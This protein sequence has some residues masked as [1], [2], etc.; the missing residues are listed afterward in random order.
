MRAG[1]PT[2]LLLDQRTGWRSDA[3]STVSDGSVLELRTRPDG[4]LGLPSPDGSLG[5][6]TLPQGMAFDRSQT[7][8]L[9]VGDA[10][11]RY[12]V[13]VNGF[14]VVP[15]TGG[16]GTDARHFL[17]PSAIAIH[18]RNLY[19][20][21]TGH[22]RVLVFAL[23]S[24]TLVHTFTCKD[25]V[26]LAGGHDG[27]YILDRMR[28]R[29]Y[30]HR[31]GESRWRRVVDGRASANR[32]TRLAIDR[33]GRVY[34]FDP[35][36]VVLDVFDPKSTKVGEVVD[37]GSVRD[38]FDPPAIRLDHRFRF[39][40]PDALMRECDRRAPAM[41]PPPETPLALCRAGTGRTFDRSGQPVSVAPDE[42]LGPHIHQTSGTW[43]SEPLDSRLHACLW[44]R[45]EV[46]VGRLPVGTRLHVSTYV[47]AEPRPVNEIRPE[48][49][50]TC[51]RLTAP[52]QAPNG[53]RGKGRR[54]SLVQSREG[55]YLR[56]RV[57]LFGDGYETPTVAALRIH[58]PRESYLRYLPAIYSAEDESRSFLERLLSVAQTEWDQLETGIAEFARHLDPESVPAGP[59]MTFLGQW[60]ALPLEQTW[61]W[62]QKRRLLAAT[63]RLHPRRGTPDGVAEYIRIYLRNMTGLSDDA[64]VAYPQ[65]VEG[66]N[67]RQ[68]LQLGVSGNMA[69]VSPLWSADVVGRLQLDTHAQEGSARLVSTGDPERDLFHEYAHRFRVFVPA[70][71]VRTASDERMLRRAIEAAK[72][73]HTQYDLCL[74]EAR[75]RVGLQS[76]VG[77]DTLVGAH[78]QARLAC[79]HEEDRAPSRAPRHRLGYDTVL[80]R[81]SDGD[82]P[83]APTRVGVDTILM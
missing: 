13:S 78:P 61:S 68:R 18:G 69:A 82:A 29:V 58:F 54:E 20:A 21:D 77:I 19:V 57:E 74:V 34:L 60:L 25:P 26:D 8:H 66:F 10:L 75:F 12:D 39:C 52:A 4:P 38:R 37:P 81:R 46:D 1:T 30:R 32:W 40:L 22:H 62:D 11:K 73:A 27:V 53:D 65:I 51:L 83:V 17:N 67:E 63:P 45:V 6:L 3:S 80:A 41:P 35:E 79:S 43:Y 50:D 15:D 24:Y 36:R 28:G 9:L 33:S 44:H 55:R 59:F 2:F 70:A 64:Q 31:P 76:T 71:W 16:S 48:R 47:D 14:V 5:G 49:W 7:L 42:A 23:P 56:L 72:P